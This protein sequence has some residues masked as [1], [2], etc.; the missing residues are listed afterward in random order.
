M[1]FLNYAARLRQIR[2]G[3]FK[4]GINAPFF[5]DDQGWTIFPHQIPQIGGRYKGDWHIRDLQG[6]GPF[7]WKS[8]KAVEQETAFE[9]PTLSVPVSG[10]CA[11]ILSGGKIGGQVRIEDEQSGFKAEPALPPELEGGNVM[12]VPIPSSAVYRTIRLTALSE[13]ICFLGIKTLQPQPWLPR[14]KFDYSTLPPA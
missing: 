7:V 3:D 10:P 2:E 6:F 12:Q 1:D 14:V 11:F 13:G 5:R 4:P 9:R 8:G